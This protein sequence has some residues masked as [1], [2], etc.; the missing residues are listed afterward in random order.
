MTLPLAK[1]EQPSVSDL[2]AESRT[3]LFV[4]AMLFAG[5]ALTPIHIRNLSTTGALIEGLALPA[6]GAAVS[7]RRASLSIDGILAWRSKNQAGIAFKS[8]IF[9]PAWLPRSSSSRQCAIDLM[10]FD[11]KNGSGIATKPPQLDRALSDPNS[12][13]VELTSLRSDLVN[14]GDVLV[15]D[16]ILVATHPEIQLLDIA[17]QRI[18]RLLLLAAASGMAPGQTEV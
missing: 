9:V 15:Q 16:I 4:G 11:S 18:D 7:I 8:N 13:F 5:T 17:V 12:A 1:Y 3:H 10:V 14:L 6:V 2:R